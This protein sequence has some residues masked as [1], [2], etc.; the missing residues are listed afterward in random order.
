MEEDVDLQ[1]SLVMRSPWEWPQEVCRRWSQIDE[2]ADDTAST[3]QFYVEKVEI[4]RTLGLKRRSFHERKT[5]S[6]HRGAGTHGNRHSWRY[7]EG[8]AR[9]PTRIHCH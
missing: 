3:R 4:R 8:R 7:A 6:R 2:G 5:R 9:D 1:Q